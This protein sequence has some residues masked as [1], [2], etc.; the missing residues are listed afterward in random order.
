[1]APV[2]NLNLEDMASAE[3]EALLEAVLAEQT[4]R[5]SVEIEKIAVNG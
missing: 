4:R 5:Q 1:M 3:F 2:Q